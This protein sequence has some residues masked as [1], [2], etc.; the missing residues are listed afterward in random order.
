MGIDRR[1]YKLFRAATSQVNFGALIVVW[2]K[3]FGLCH[4]YIFGICIY[5]GMCVFT[6]EFQTLN[7]SPSVCLTVHL[8]LSLCN[9][10]LR[11]W[12]FGWTYNLR[13]FEIVKVDVPLA[14]LAN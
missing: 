12:P 2:V 3:V 1:T 5:R 7:G 10:H 11:F 8:Y 4:G 14:S 6:I 13:S 9:T